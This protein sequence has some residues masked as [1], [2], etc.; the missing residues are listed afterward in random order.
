MV[1]NS[2][3]SEENKWYVNIITG[4][5]GMFTGFLHGAGG[6]IAK[7][8]IGKIT[9]YSYVEETVTLAKDIEDHE[10]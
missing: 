1:E 10:I 6:T 8:K 7:L 5:A 3:E 9:A 2:G 4:F